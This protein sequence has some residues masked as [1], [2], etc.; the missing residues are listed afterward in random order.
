MLST[1]MDSVGDSG[2]HMADDRPRRLANYTLATGGGQLGGDSSH[3]RPCGLAKHKLATPGDSLTPLP[4]FWFLTLS[5]LLTLLPRVDSI[6]TQG[7]SWGGQL[8]PSSL[9]AGK[10]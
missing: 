1:K 8:A 5:V 3:Y 9:W 10:A 7:D 2:G 6:A 4:A